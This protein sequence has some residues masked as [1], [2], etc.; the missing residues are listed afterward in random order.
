MR[1]FSYCH[2]KLSPKSALRVFQSAGHLPSE[3]AR[4]KEAVSIPVFGNGD[5]RTADDAL[6]MLAQTG[7][8]GVMIGRGATK[9]PWLFQQIAARQERGHP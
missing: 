7:C 5:V 4:L 3:I 6:Q 2:P 9:N 8:D 1:R